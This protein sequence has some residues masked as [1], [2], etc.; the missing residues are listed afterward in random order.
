MISDITKSIYFK[1]M[2][3]RQQRVIQDIRQDSS[4]NNEFIIQEQLP[5]IYKHFSVW[6]ESYIIKLKNKEKNHNNPARDHQADCIAERKN[7]IELYIDQGIKEQIFSELDL[8]LLQQ[9]ID[10]HEINDQHLNQLGYA[11]IEQDIITVEWLLNKGQDI[12]QVVRLTPFGIR[13]YALQLAIYDDIENLNMLHFFIKHGANIHQLPLQSL[14][15]WGNKCFEYSLING[16]V[17]YGKLDSFKLLV[18]YG[19]HFEPLS[20]YKLAKIFLCICNQNLNFVG[21][22]QDIQSIIDYFETVIPLEVLSGLAAIKYPPINNDIV[23]ER[24]LL[25]AYGKFVTNLIKSA[26]IKFRLTNRIHQ[27]ST[28]IGAPKI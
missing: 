21:N 26:E 24:I 3:I 22:I 16:A 20:V 9:S 1:I 11:I 7:F 28:D 19:A 27:V 13:D 15:M 18:E 25:F 2:Y 17:M 23:K 6:A 10:L 5:K 12:N 4:L 14:C 8:L